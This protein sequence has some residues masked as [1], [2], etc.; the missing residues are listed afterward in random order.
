MLAAVMYIAILWLTLASFI[1]RA[2]SWV[3]M[4]VS[5]IV[6]VVV[7]LIARPRS[8]QTWALVSGIIFR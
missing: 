5:L 8:A 4:V 7:S 1:S 6:V 3:V 2:A